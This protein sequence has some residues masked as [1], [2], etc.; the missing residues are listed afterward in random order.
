MNSLNQQQ[1]AIIEGYLD[2]QGFTFLPLRN[3]MLDHLMSDIESH[4]RRG[5]TFEEAWQL[6][7]GEIPSGHFKNLQTE[8]M[9]ATNKRFNLARSFALLSLSLLLATSL[10]KL[11]H[12]QY[13]KMLLMASLGAII[14]AL[15][16]STISGISLHKQRKGRGM[17]IVTVA[18]IVLLLASWCMRILHL[19]GT[20][21]FSLLS[22]TLLLVLFP[23][24]IIYFRA[25]SS[26]DSNILMYLHEK[27]T[28]GIN[29]FLLI[30]LAIGLIL[31]LVS[32]SLAYE[33]GIPNVLLGLAI[34]GSGLQ[35]FALHWHQRASKV[36]SMR[37]YAITFMLV[38]GFVA[39]TI[40]ILPYSQPLS[41]KVVVATIFYLIAGAMILRES[42]RRAIPLA[43]VAVSWVYILAWAAAS[44]EWVDTTMKEAIFSLPVLVMLV[45]ALVASR[46]YRTLMTYMMIVVANFLLFY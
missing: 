15:I 38:V 44:L 6:T 22:T 46:Q 12:W 43:V 27:H 3:E 7:V 24:L 21:L 1:R 2:E 41:L 16:V 42:N 18:G 5:H 26:D 39:F 28:P 13:A 14:T 29:R 32:V 35:F 11:M 37:D 9:E 36:T 33:V 23:A 34:G 19:P 17:L 25:G 4:I 40:P 31:K 45:G 8:T 20:S 30:L 10:F